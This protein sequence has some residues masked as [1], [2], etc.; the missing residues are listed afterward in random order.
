MTSPRAWRAQH[1]GVALGILSHKR[2]ARRTGQTRQGTAP[3]HSPTTEIEIEIDIVGYPEPG[4]AAPF[5]VRAISMPVSDSL[6]L[7]L[8]GFFA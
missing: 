4:Y 1:I 5:F 3:A 8:A 2:C 6:L 7:L